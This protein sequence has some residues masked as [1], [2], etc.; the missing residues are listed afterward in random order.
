[1]ELKGMTNINSNLAEDQRLIDEDLTQSKTAWQHFEREFGASNIVPIA[2]PSE[3]VESTLPTGV[4]GKV[5]SRYNQKGEIVGYHDWQTGRAT[6]AD[7]Q[8]WQADGRYGFGVILGRPLPSGGVAV[9]VDVDTE[10]E[11][12]QAKVHDLITA[13]IGGR[14]AMRVRENSNRRA[15]VV[16]VTCE[17]EISKRVMTLRKADKAAGIKPEAVEF[18]ATGQQ[19]AAWG[20]HPSGAE[21]EWLDAPAQSFT[22][23]RIYPELALHSLT[24]EQFEELQQEIADAF[25]VERAAIEDTRARNGKAANDDAISDDVALFLDANGWTLDTGKEGQRHIRSPFESEYTNEQGNNDTS[26]TYFSAGTRNYEQGHF[27]SHHASDEARTDA[28]FLEAIGYIASQFPDLTEGETPEETAAAAGK[29]KPFLSGVKAGRALTGDELERLHAMNAEYVHTVAGG[30][31]VICQIS[32]RTLAGVTVQELQYIRPPEFSG[33][34]ISADPIY[35]VITDVEGNKKK[36]RPLNIADAWQAWPSHAQKF[37]GVDFHPNPKAC[38]RDVYNLFTGFNVQ[39]AAGDVAPYLDLVTRLI[40]GGNEIHADY[41][42]D[43]LAHMLQKPEQKPSVAVVMRGGRGIGKSSFMKPISQILGMH[44]ANLTGAGQA[45]GRFNAVI[46]GKL[47]IFLDELR[48]TTRDAEDALK[49]IISEPQ[50]SIERKGIDPEPFSNYARV[51]GASNHM[52]AIRTG[53]SE[54]RYLLLASSDAEKD[55]KA[56]WDAFYD[57]L[58]AD[59]AAHLLSF[60]QARD[61]SKFDPFNAPRTDALMAAMVEDLTPINRYVLEQ[62]RRNNPFPTSDFDDLSTDAEKD[63]AAPV[64]S[65]EIRTEKAAED[66]LTWLNEH[67]PKRSGQ[68]WNIDHAR[69]GLRPIFNRVFGIK[70]TG[71]RG[72]GYGRVY[73]VE[74]FEELR[75]RFADH[76]GVSY[77]A[78]FGQHD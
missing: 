47:C 58:K 34:F 14:V 45:A 28:D 1:M 51:F 25:A 30:K 17:K 59:G 12:H 64:I 41:V 78:A 3:G 61:I 42:L 7:L 50:I 18:L 53:E 11:E 21:L 8:R 68:A 4:I 35:G 77:E 70:A 52:D 33:R 63:T 9:C 5:P 67:H 55:N 43:L 76:I 49:M 48:V 27:V 23:E 22:A 31:N 44:A 37:G 69:H 40:C 26:V 20:R 60:L 13:K 32:R 66:L 36:G 38:P 56:Y 2:Q 54:R 10:N 62:L 24:E 75:E 74:D 6:P 57:W 73:Q 65:A 71:R 72:T 19:F 39:P 16:R 15:Y 29:G 46:V